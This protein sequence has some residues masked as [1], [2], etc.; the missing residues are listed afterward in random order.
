MKSYLFFVFLYFDSR[1]CNWISNGK[2]S[3]TIAHSSGVL[4]GQDFIMTEELYSEENSTNTHPKWI[5]LTF[6]TLRLF[7][8]KIFL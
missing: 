8:W 5:H 3:T 1:T 6:Y 4:C 7:G 2:E